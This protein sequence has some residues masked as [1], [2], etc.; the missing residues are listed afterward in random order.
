[1]KVVWKSAGHLYSASFLA[2]YIHALEITSYSELS[3]IPKLHQASQSS[4][5]KPNVYG[6]NTQASTCLSKASPV[7]SPNL[8][9]TSPSIPEPTQKFPNI[10]QL[11]PC[12]RSFPKTFLIHCPCL[13]KL[14]SAAEAPQRVSSWLSAAPSWL[15][16][17]S[18]WLAEVSSWQAGVSSWLTGDTSWLAGVSSC[19]DGVSSWRA[20]VSSWP[21]GV[22]SWLARI[23][24]WLATSPLSGDLGQT[25]DLNVRFKTWELG[26][27]TWDLD[28]GTWDLGPQT[29]DLRPGSRDL[30]AGT[31]DLEPGTW[32]LGRGTCNWGPRT[33][34]VGL[35]TWDQDMGPV[36]W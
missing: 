15:A 27:G 12:T 1:M 3:S 28:P 21:A 9:Q 4:L 22:S 20:G 18:A 13:P 7:H 16:G 34:G 5:E 2:E 26:H 19:L 11:S 10:L 6:T 24:S 14:H 31:G 17:V 25:W 29:W 35:G 30:G 32:N 33:W 23:S 8:L 36:T